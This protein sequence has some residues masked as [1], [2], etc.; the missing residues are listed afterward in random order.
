MN[1]DEKRLMTPDQVREKLRDRKIS[2]VAEKCSVSYVTLNNLMKG[3]NPS[4]KTLAKL[5]DYLD[6]NE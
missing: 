4:V 1:R 6:G 2:Y 3:H 5:T